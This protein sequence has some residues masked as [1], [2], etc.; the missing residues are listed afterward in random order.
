LVAE[1]E[2]DL[3][4]PLAEAEVVLLEEGA[5]ALE[6]EAKALAVWSLALLLTRAR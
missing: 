6:E 3:E 4:R 5:S 1:A 2:A